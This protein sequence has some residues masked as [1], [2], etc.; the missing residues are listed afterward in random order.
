MET[1]AEDL[2][3][4][5][6][7]DLESHAAKTKTC[8][9]PGNN[10]Y[11]SCSGCGKY[12]SD[13][14]GNT[15]IEENSWVIPASHDTLSHHAVKAKTCTTAGNSAYWECGA[16]HKYFSDA[17]AENEIDENSWIIPA[18]HETLSHH[19]AKEAN[20]TESGNSA[21]WSCGACGRYF[22]DADGEHE[23]E[24]GSWVIP[25]SHGTL[26][27]HA[28]VAKTCT[29]AGNSAY[30]SCSV[31][32]KFFNDKDG[33]HEIDEDSWIIPA[34]HDLES[35]AAKAKTCTAAGNSAYWSCG[36]CDKYFNDAEGQNEIDEDS[37]II[38]AG[39]TLTGHP[40]VAKAKCTDTG[41]SAYWSCSVCKKY[42]SDAEGNTEV[43]RDS[44]IIPAS[45]HQWDGGVEDP[46]HTDTENGV[47]T[48]TCTVCGETKTEM[49]P[50]NNL[51]TAKDNAIAELNRINTG[52][53]SGAEKTKVE[54]AIAEAKEKIL[55]AETPTAVEAAMSAARST[56]GAQKTNAQKA[57]AAAAPKTKPEKVDLKAIK[58]LKV[59]G[60]KKK[61]TV[62]WKK[63][64]K[65]ELKTFQG[66]EI[67]YTLDGTFKDYPAKKVSKKKASAT[68]KKLL[69]K[70]KYKVRIRRYRDDGSVLHVS[71]W[72]Q[73]KAK[74][75]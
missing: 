69:K 68:L 14:E 24:A 72:K 4:P 2:K 30:W 36:A 43:A 59:K 16:C 35:H 75:K 10:A 27:P 8:T 29:T 62:K 37:W 40:A 57:A 17:N 45:E 41:S 48:Y 6:G 67:Q 66:Y 44:W 73:K 58:G 7:H 51:R 32:G 47:K 39:H 19:A 11:W 53:Y 33:K 54:A 50:S 5:A 9:E 49:V 34:G 64:T 55:R 18:S 71:K 12:F 65:K 63:A 70:K 3:I 20:C 31:C 25:A 46:M 21:Y 26:T 1:D 74:T 38:P 13:A 28:A 22:S 52:D 42:F 60:A 56:I 15:E 23:I 61:L